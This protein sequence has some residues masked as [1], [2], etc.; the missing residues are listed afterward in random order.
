MPALSEIASL[1]MVGALKYAHTRFPTLIAADRVTASEATLVVAWAIAVSA[2][3]KLPTKSPPAQKLSLMTIEID[4]LSAVLP[5]PSLRVKV[6]VDS[7]GVVGVPEIT[8]V[9]PLRL[10]P[11]GSDPEVS[12]Q[13]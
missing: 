11:A 13:P 3:V 8:P 10:S 6:N 7:P 2:C 12:D 4:G 9:A 5:K 1:P